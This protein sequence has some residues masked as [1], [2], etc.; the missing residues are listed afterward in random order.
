LPFESLQSFQVWASINNLTDRD[1]P[2]A[3]GGV[4]GAN[5]IFFDSLGRTYRAGVRMQF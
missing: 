5:A 1:P 2:F 3:N 4:G